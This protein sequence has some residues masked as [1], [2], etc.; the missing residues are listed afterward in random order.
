V[1]TLPAAVNAVAFAPTG[2]DLISGAVDGSLRLTHDDGDPIALPMSSAG[3]D[4]VAIL[5]DGRIAVADANNL[6]IIR[7]DRDAPLMDVP[8]PSR[9]RLM[10]PSP[11]GGRLVAISIPSEQSPPMLWDLDK[12]RLVGRLEGHTG[13][14]FTARFVTD[15]GREILTVGSDGTS[16]LWGT[17]TGD[18]RRT[19]RGD[20]HVLVDAVLAPDG[21]MVIAG[22]SD[23]FLRFWDTSSG[24]LL[25]MLQA[26]ASYVVG[27]HYEG[28][29]LITRGM[30]G[31]IA[32]WALSP[33]DG[34]IEA[35]RLSLCAPTRER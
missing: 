30:A 33:S 9:I 7:T 1:I 28:N 14:V 10:R 18:L 20:G 25:W 8:A 23:G 3:I 17:V 32:R 35:C 11:D 15:G 19:F 24:R 6:R 27:L 34:L 31:D 4:A 13:R 2:H 16:R 29:D 21:S 5:S 26:H 22:G 12:Y